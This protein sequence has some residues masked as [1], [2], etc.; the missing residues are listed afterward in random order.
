MNILFFLD[1]YPEYGG[2]EKVT[3][4]L[5]EYLT[6]QGHRVLIF[7][8]R[9]DHSDELLPALYKNVLTFV[10]EDG[11]RS[12]VQLRKILLEYEIDKLIYQDSYV[13]IDTI[14]REAVAGTGIEVIVVE[15]N[16][17]DAFLRAFKCRDR[18][19]SFWY[20]TKRALFYPLYE[21]KIKRQVK[22]W[23]RK[24]MSFADKYVVLSSSYLPILE[25]MTGKIPD[26]KAFFINN[27][28]TVPFPDSFPEGVS[29]TC[30]FC[31]RLTAQKGVNRL[32][33]IW[34]SYDK[35]GTGWNLTIVG[36]GQERDFMEKEIARRNIG[37]ISL[38][39]YCP[40]PEIYY[41]QSSV[42]LMT[43][44]YEGWS[45]T[46]GEAMANGCVPIVFNSFSAAEDIVENGK[47]GILVK[48]FLKDNFVEN[49]Y[50]LTTD[51]TLLET[52]RYNAW[53]S[54]RKFSMETIGQKWLE[55]LNCK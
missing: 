32:L 2:I 48:P 50:R 42:F 30:L 33:D 46:L 51:D 29:H 22:N 37:H 36:D 41:V 54:A 39:G 12:A 44:S 26:E 7:S 24:M 55:L 21:F 1:R 49:L 17:P 3:T 11:V 23:H 53:Q 15:H 35:L 28:I 8:I 31:A 20:K 5:A 27:P 34:E 13:P 6:G 18:R 14:A 25:Q 40:T 38:K 16:T 52:M 43:S 10:A 45:L 19:Y 4:R 47:N 9:Q